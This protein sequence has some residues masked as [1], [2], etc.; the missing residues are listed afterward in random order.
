MLIRVFAKLPRYSLTSFR[1]S[2]CLPVDAGS[3]EIQL[4]GTAIKS[5]EE[6]FGSLQLNAQDYLEFADK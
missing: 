5:R 3:Q 4:P 6:E 1:F 2:E